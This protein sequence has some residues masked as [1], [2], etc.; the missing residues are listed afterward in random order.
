VAAFQMLDLRE[1]AQLGFLGRG[2][3]GDGKKCSSASSILVASF[4]PNSAA[5]SA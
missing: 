1:F 5:F 3:V 4:A 2:V